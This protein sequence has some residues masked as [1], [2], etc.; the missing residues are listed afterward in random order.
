MAKPLIETFKITGFNQETQ[1]VTLVKIKV[2]EEE[3]EG[4]HRENQQAIRKY[5]A[6]AGSV[7]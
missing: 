4:I 5:S 7:N 2:P 6:M 1:E 3:L